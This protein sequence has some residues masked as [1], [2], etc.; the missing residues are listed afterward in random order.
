[1]RS[2][3][4]TAVESQAI[5]GLAPFLGG[6]QPNGKQYQFGKSLLREIVAEP[7]IDCPS[8][9][10]Q[11]N[12][13]NGNGGASLPAVRSGDETR[14]SASRTRRPGSAPSSPDRAPRRASAR[15]QR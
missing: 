14:I 13:P 12:S 2:E 9:S 8:R 6:C 4:G 1:M 11:P 15:G 10:D 7:R 5:A 3:P